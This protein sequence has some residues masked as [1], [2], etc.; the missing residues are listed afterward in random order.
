MVGAISKV[1]GKAYSLLGEA[2]KGAPRIDGER[3][4]PEMPLMAHVPWCFFCGKHLVRIGCRYICEHCRALES[5]CA[6]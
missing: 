6:F 3:A 2:G 5:A 1:N 4:L